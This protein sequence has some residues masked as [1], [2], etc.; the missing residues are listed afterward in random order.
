M[1]RLRQETT[2]C[3]KQ[4]CR[5]YSLEEATTGNEI[6]VWI[7]HVLNLLGKNLTDA[8]VW[9][10]DSLMNI[11]PSW[12][13]RLIRTNGIQH[14]SFAIKTIQVRIYLQ[15]RAIKPWNKLSTTNRPHF[16][17]PPSSLVFQ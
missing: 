12:L 6:A 1:G 17:R 8:I 9:R 5:G 16:D 13:K 7:H 15:E 2:E 10:I 11:S 4:R 3:R 14:T